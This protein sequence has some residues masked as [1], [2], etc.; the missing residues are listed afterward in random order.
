MAHAN[1][2]QMRIKLVWENYVEKRLIYIF[3]NLSKIQ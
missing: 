3:K 2:F 1:Q